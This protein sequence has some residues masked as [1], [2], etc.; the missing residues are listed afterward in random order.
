MAQRLSTRQ[1]L[2][3]TLPS[4]KADRCLLALLLGLLVVTLTTSTRPF[5]L[6]YKYVHSEESLAAAAEA[7][8]RNRTQA[9]EQYFVRTTKDQ[10]QTH[11]AGQLQNRSW[12]IQVRLAIAIVSV[13]REN[14]SAPTV[15]HVIQSAAALDSL[16]RQQGSSDDLFGDSV[17]FVCNVDGFPEVNTAADFLRD[18]V[19]F[20]ERY[21]ESSAGISLSRLTIPGSKGTRYRDVFHWDLYEKERYDYMF[22]LQSAMAFR[23][24]YVLIVQDDAL[25]LPDMPSVVQHALQRL[26]KAPGRYRNDHKQF[27]SSLSSNPSL[28]KIRASAGSER[29]FNDTEF[30]DELAALSG[31]VYLKLYFPLYWQ[32]FAF[33]LIPVFDLLCMAE[34]LA[35]VVIVVLQIYVY[36]GR[37]PPKSII[38]KVTVFILALCLLVGR[39]NLNELRRLS[40]HFYRL[41]SSSECC[42]PAVLYPC[43]VV[44]ALLT[45]LSRC[46]DERHVD[47]CISDFAKHSGLPAYSLEPNL[48]SHTGTI[49]TLNMTDKSPEELLFHSTLTVFSAE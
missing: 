18:Y 29:D 28:S 39:Q 1:A 46:Q 7:I 19:H 44:P 45:S 42:I 24:H 34:V 25:A 35:S 31:F 26:T 32:G 6:L 9:A 3:M 37:V 47:L 14:Y 13:R 36:K 10:Q 23:P 40:K 41:Q 30:L 43:D 33:E 8:H 20:V 49:S 15:G 22:C 4:R 27:G 38:S 12:P 48:F 5:S 17:L 2:T 16:L 21:G 11:S